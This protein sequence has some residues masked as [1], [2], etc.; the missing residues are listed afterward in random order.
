MTKSFS[1]YSCSS[2]KFLW[3]FLWFW[4]FKF[5]LKICSFNGIYPSLSIMA[6]HPGNWEKDATSVK[7]LCCLQFVVVEVNG[8]TVCVPHLSSCD[9]S[10]GRLI[11]RA[12]NTDIC[13]LISYSMG[14]AEGPKGSRKLSWC[15]EAATMPRQRT[16]PVSILNICQFKVHIEGWT[17]QRLNPANLQFQR[18]TAALAVHTEQKQLKWL[19]IFKSGSANARLPQKSICDAAQTSQVPF[20]GGSVQTDTMTP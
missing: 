11:Q 14:R 17:F 18:S 8:K 12:V 9:I 1:V 4:H 7:S 15:T 6:T 19:L 2:Y 10:E 13:M 5:Q 20:F 3:A 16:I